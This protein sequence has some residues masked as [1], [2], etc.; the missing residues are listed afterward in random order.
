[1]DEVDVVA[2]VEELLQT[3]AYI[4]YLLN[5]FYQP[6]A[7][8][9]ASFRAGNLATARKL[10]ARRQRQ[11]PRIIVLETQLERVKAELARLGF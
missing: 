4:E 10:L 2:K 1:M 3:Q 9:A 11:L 5:M 8:I 6:Y 7:P